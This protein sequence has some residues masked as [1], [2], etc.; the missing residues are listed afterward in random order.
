[1]HNFNWI[2]ATLCLSACAPA[3]G[4][5]A[6]PNQVPVI[7][8]TA[9]Y[10]AN[11]RGWTFVDT[12]AT[13]IKKMTK[14]DDPIFDGA[15]AWYGDVQSRQPEDAALKALE[16]EGFSKPKVV[17]IQESHTVFIRQ[18]DSN[19][20]AS[21]HLMVVDGQLSKQPA[22]AV[23]YC[24]YGNIPDESGNE[25]TTHVFMAPRPVF[26][27]L[28]GIVVPSV[29]YL[30]AIAPKDMKMLDYGKLSPNEATQRMATVV[31]SWAVNY[32]LVNLEMLRSMGQTMSL[33]QQV[34]DS[35]Q[36]YNSALSACGGWDCNFSQSS[37]G[38][39]TAIPD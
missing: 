4:Q 33:N 32:L 27:A 14:P 7:V 11:L 1:M 9:D 30:Q 21:V 8:E 31:D 15:V 6:Y 17:S 35:M 39:W 3:S 18:L 19:K 36:S 26:E 38:T 12:D 5:P 20:N 13:H 34:L 28:G 2:L 25:T 10:Q 24:W 29:L 16:L 23:V 22:R 37:D